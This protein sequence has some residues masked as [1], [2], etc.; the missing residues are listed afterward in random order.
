MHMVAMFLQASTVIAFRSQTCTERSNLIK[1]LGGGG[2]GTRV[3][4]W[5]V[6][7]C[8]KDA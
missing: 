1:A 3:R 8:H 4:P 5:R 7:S 2:G 6:S